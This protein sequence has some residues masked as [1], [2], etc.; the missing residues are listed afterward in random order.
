MHPWHLHGGRSTFTAEF[1][2]IVGTGGVITRLENGREFS[3]IPLSAF[4]EED[5]HYIAELARRAKTQ[6]ADSVSSPSSLV[7]ENK[8]EECVAV[9]LLNWVTDK[10]EEVKSAAQMFLWPGRSVPMTVDGKYVHAKRCNWILSTNGGAKR[11]FTEMGGPAANGKRANMRIAIS[12]A[13]LSGA[14]PANVIE[15]SNADTTETLGVT[16]TGYVDEN[17]RRT[18]CHEHWE[19]GTA[20]EVV[21][22]RDGEVVLGSEVS[23]EVATGPRRSPKIAKYRP[24]YDWLSFEVRVDDPSNPPP[25]YQQANA[26]I[27]FVVLLIIKREADIHSKFFRPVR[28]RMTD[29]D[30]EAVTRAFRVYTAE[31]VARLT[32]GRVAWLARVVV[33]DTPLRTVNGD[34]DCACCGACN[35]YED[36]DKYAPLGTCDGVFV[37]FKHIDDRTGYTLPRPFGL[38]IGP[39]MDAN[40][41]GQSCVSWVEPSEWT[42]GSDTTDI[43]LHEWLHQL[44]GFYGEKGVRLPKGGLHGAEQHGYTSRPPEFWRPWYRD[45]LNG[46]IREDGQLVGL[47]E[48]AWKR[49]TIRPAAFL[50]PDP[51]SSRSPPP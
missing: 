3:P 9:W 41:A 29:A 8:T 49:G 33:S 51:R 10:G 47:G 7:F 31:S 24:P 13:M 2:E 38:S 34:K 46:T 37:Y 30:I 15:F 22:K 11:Y 44:E 39:N 42:R 25:A 50:R 48:K 35:W 26:T 21:L 19:L 23:Y 16:C 12:D 36:L 4:S 6:R 1:V 18:V 5:Q 43:F 40:W 17:G 28:N 32:R 27:T 45:F 14:N 20:D